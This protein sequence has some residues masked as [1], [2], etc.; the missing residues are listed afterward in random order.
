MKIANLGRLIAFIIIVGLVVGA[1]NLYQSHGSI[2]F[3]GLK[4]LIPATTPG[5]AGA[6]G[7]DLLLL[8]TPS[9]AGWLQDQVDEFNKDQS[10]KY[11]ITLQYAESRQGMQDIINGKTKPVLF[12]PSSPIWISRL[13]AYTAEHDS[14]AYIDPDDINTCRV[15]LRTPLVVLTTKEKAAYLSQIFTSPMPW[16]TI[17]LYSIG[18]KHAPWGSIKF[19]HADPLVANSG[20]LTLG[21]ILS[22]YADHSDSSKPLEQLATDPGFLTYLTDIEKGLL[23]DQPAKTGSQPLVNAYADDPTSRDFITAYE[24]A[25]LSAASAN[26]D[27]VVI[28]PNPTIISD[29]MV[30]TL[31]ADWVTPD[32]AQGAQLFM[33]QLASQDSL[34]DGLK[35][36]MRPYSSNGSLSLDSVLEQHASQGFQASYHKAI[37]MPPYAALNDAAFQWRLH[38]AHMPVQ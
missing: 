29:E 27:L 10:G 9:K 33:Q 20:M 26:P 30:G 31:Q 14:K 1:Y 24:S 7:T 34:Q 12:S 6:G 15:F 37:E 3:T 38:V 4:S 2:S 5:G 8:T 23:Y 32:Q 22:E 28:Y 18:R 35:Y 17:R 36:D 19:S 11:H 13:A 25:A 21:L 16:S